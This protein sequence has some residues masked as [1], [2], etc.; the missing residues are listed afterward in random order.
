[1]TA[2]DALATVDD[3]NRPC[4]CPC[5]GDDPLRDDDGDSVVCPFNH[6]LNGDGVTVS[7]LD[8]FD[9]AFASIPKG[10]RFHHYRA[11]EIAVA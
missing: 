3:H 8:A 11:A 10:T 9:R 5:C 2:N 7:E 1:M 6:S 4:A